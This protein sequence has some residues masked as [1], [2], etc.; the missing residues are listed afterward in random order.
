MDEQEE[1]G[2]SPEKSSK[3]TDEYLQRA[4][5]LGT[6][7]PLLDVFYEIL[8]EKRIKKY[9]LNIVKEFWIF[10]GLFV[11]SALY[12]LFGINFMEVIFFLFAIV[13]TL[14]IYNLAFFKKRLLP[15]SAS[16]IKRFISD[17]KAK[18]LPEIREFIKDYRNQL[19]EPDIKS[20]FDSDHGN[21]WVLYD[22]VLK[23]QD[24]SDSIL[25]YFIEKDRLKIIGENLFIRYLKE[26]R[27]GFSYDNYLFITNHFKDNKK[28]LKITNLFNP[29]YWKTGGHIRKAANSIQSFYG[30]SKRG[31]IAD[32]INIVS[33]LL[34][35]IIAILNYRQI[36]APYATIEPYSSFP[37]I[38]VINYGFVI[39]FA[40]GIL[41]V[42]FTIVCTTIARFLWFILGFFAP[43]QP[44]I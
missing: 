23:Y 16:N 19:K 3:L 39:L 37:L 26:F 35:I 4:S 17:I 42:I 34:V 14:I 22:Y 5:Y 44:Q 21:Y 40:T 36:V 7:L 43:D 1:V 15:D 2:E 41:I 32:G 25:V 28:I 10:F 12:Y 13:F 6:I 24:F 20:I 27:M 38:L 30:S 18:K 9:N 8:I 11:I 31:R 33:F 29:S